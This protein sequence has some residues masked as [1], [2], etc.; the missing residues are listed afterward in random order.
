VAEFSTA[1]VIRASSGL[2][3]I[4]LGVFCLF[5]VRGRRIPL[6]LGAYFLAFGAQFVLFNL[7]AHDPTWAR[8]VMGMG[9]VW[10]LTQVVCLVLAAREFTRGWP[11]PSTLEGL[12]Y[13]GLFVAWFSWT[14]AATYALSPPQLA[15]SDGVDPSATQLNYVRNGFVAF[16]RA[17]GAVFLL[18]LAVQT[19]RRPAQAKVSTA[20]LALFSLSIYLPLVVSATA[21]LVNPATVSLLGV[22]SGAFVVLGYFLIAAA[23][24]PWGPGPDRRLRRATGLTMFAGFLI[25]PALFVFNGAFYSNA[26]TSPLLGILRFGAILFVSWAVFRHGLLGF[27]FRTRIENRGTWAAVTLATLFIVAQVAQSYLSAE[28]GLLSGSLIAGALLFAAQPVQRALERVGQ[29]PLR[30]ESV[31]SAASTDNE[32]A[33][34]DALHFA[35]RDRRLTRDEEFRLAGIADRLG[36]GARRALE[37]RDEVEGKGKKRTSPVK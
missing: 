24:Y 31:V 8:L 36:I 37:L 1:I 25:G 14:L 3:F 13:V 2:A 34:R 15:V 22:P 23:W 32:D 9:S 7:G 4:L 29:R 19:R 18:F 28:M 17:V 26:S 35:L 33:Y 5:F 21:I 11:L 27:R 30:G 6:I 20:A 12:G 10:H 16:S